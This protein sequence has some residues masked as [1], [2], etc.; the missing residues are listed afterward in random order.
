MHDTS[1]GSE[2]MEVPPGPA[3]S[4]DD[5]EEDYESDETAAGE[6][7]QR[8]S[9]GGAGGGRA[10]GGGRVSDVDPVADAMMQKILSSARSRAWRNAHHVIGCRL[11]CSI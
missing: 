7:G 2:S 10:G 5:L 8:G 4:E 11:I 3:E 1:P 9:G 6:G